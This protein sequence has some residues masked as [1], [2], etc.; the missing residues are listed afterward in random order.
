MNQKKQ[1]PRRQKHIPQRT[2]VIC[3]QRFDKRR[4]T[5]VVRTSESG[6]VIDPTGKQNGRGAYLCDQSA[7]W[8]QALRDTHLL[9]KALLTTISEEEWAAIAVHKP[10]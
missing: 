2:C 7:C 3:R 9:S 8:E 10:E 1:K 4:L 6:V 5:R